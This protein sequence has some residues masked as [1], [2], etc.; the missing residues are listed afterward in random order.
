LRAHLAEL[1]G[2]FALVFFGCGAIA[3][4][5]SPAPVAIAFGL[6]IAVMI[7]GFGHISGAHYNPAVSAAFAVGRHFPWPRVVT[8]AVAQI[9]GAIAGAAALRATLG[10]NASLGVTHPSGSELQAFAWEAILTFFLV[11]VITAVATDVRAVGQAAALAIGGTVALD[12][13]VGGPISGAS[14]NP[15][16]SLGPALVSDDLA[17]I[18]IYVVAPLL[19]AVLA[20]Q[21]YR[22]LRGPEAPRSAAGSMILA[23]TEPDPVRESGNLGTLN[24]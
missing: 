5:L 9:L 2:T 8:Y 12:A 11:L 7:Y 10:P 16:R 21:A 23:G 17:G 6:V 14:M 1:I 19:G 3:N 24:E 20:A 22:F 4:H 15:A 13:L 18:W